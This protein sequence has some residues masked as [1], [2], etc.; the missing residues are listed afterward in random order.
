[1]ISANT[2]I[3]KEIN[4]RLEEIERK[5]TFE[6]SGERVEK[7]GREANKISVAIDGL[8]KDIGMLLLGG[9]KIG[10]IVNEFIK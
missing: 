10:G 9:E 3:E 1:M 7:V 8:S 2:E 6:V 4:Q 5:T